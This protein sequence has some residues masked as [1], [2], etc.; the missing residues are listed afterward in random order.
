MRGR[1]FALGGELPGMARRADGI[2]GGMGLH[3]RHHPAHI[4]HIGGADHLHALGVQ[5]H[6]ALMQ[7]HVRARL[8]ADASIGVENVLLRQCAL[9]LAGEGTV[10]LVPLRR[11]ES[12]EGVA[13]RGFKRGVGEQVGDRA[14]H[15]DLHLGAG[16]QGGAAG[17]ILHPLQQVAHLRQVHGADGVAYPG[18]GLH[19]VGGDAAG[20]DH[21]VMHARVAW[22]VLAEIIDAD[23]GQ[24]HRI[25]RRAAEMRCGGGVA[26][27]AVE[28]EVDSGVGQGECLGHLEEGVGVPGD[29]DIDVLKRAGAHHER[30][31]CATFLG[32][33]AVIAHAARCAGLGQPVLHRRGGQEGC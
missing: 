14:E 16:H 17:A 29:G 3:G 6:Q 32:R 5:R 1:A 27:A 11:A 25:Q 4:A 30:L 26:G 15:L 23:V 33:A 28:G 13:H 9:D 31:G 20:V 12:L 19:H 24:L 10:R 2:G 18:A 8:H 21:G 7:R 22:H